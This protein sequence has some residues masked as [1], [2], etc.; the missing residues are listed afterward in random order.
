MLSIAQLVSMLIKRPPGALDEDFG[1]LWCR[2]ICL[3]LGLDL[4]FLSLYGSTFL[5]QT[6][7]KPW[8][9]HQN[10]DVGTLLM[11]LLAIAVLGIP[12]TK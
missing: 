2:L 11:N 3:S 5:V 8:I 4:T 1:C 6:A 7:V 12:E 9:A 10:V